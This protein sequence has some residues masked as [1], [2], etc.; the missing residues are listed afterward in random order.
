MRHKSFALTALAI[1]L[2]ACTRNAGFAANSDEDARA[3]VKASLE[4]DFAEILDGK[5]TAH[6][7]LS[8][9]V[10][11]WDAAR[12]VQ[13]P[14][15]AH[16]G[17][18][19]SQPRAL[20]SAF[21]R[22]PTSFVE[23]RANGRD[24]FKNAAGTT[25]VKVKADAGIWKLLTERRNRGPGDRPL[26]AAAAL[27]DANRKFQLLSLPAD[28]RDFVVNTEMMT[29]TSEGT[30]E[31]YAR[32]VRIHRT[33]NGLRVRDSQFMVTYDLT[34]YAYRIESEWPAFRLAPGAQL[35]SRADA[36]D[37]ISNLLATRF[38]NGANLGEVHANLSYHPVEDGTFE[39]VVSVAVFPADGVGSPDV[40][41]FSLVRGP[42]QFEP[43]ST[44]V[45]G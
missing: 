20:A 35:R 30:Q 31:V 41:D 36:L 34:G 27:T 14:A 9:K 5:K 18:D 13:L 15:S 39:P 44:P 12:L 32:H 10:P 1:I 2:S 23:R 43:A 29:Q 8:E 22:E 42:I 7:V 40:V 25:T 26:D 38:T 16:A 17:P 33:I 37:E 21:T 11:Q 19:L 6:A 4:A 28:Q 24:V 45:D 3:N